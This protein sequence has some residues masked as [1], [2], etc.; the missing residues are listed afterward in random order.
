MEK[1]YYSNC[2]D[3]PPLSELDVY[4][5]KP[6]GMCMSCRDGAVFNE[7][8]RKVKRDEVLSLIDDTFSAFFG[9]KV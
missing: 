5:E 4:G 1:E 9:T 3:A 7:K 6:M 2:C 8:V